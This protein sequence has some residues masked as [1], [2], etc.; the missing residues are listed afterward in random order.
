MSMGPRFLWHCLMHFVVGIGV[1]CYE[2]QS[3]VMELA[4]RFCVVFLFA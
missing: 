4:A 2:K 1:A 3:M